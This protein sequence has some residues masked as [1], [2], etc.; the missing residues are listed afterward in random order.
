MDRAE[1]T[2]AGRDA[3][4]PGCSGRRAG[5][6]ARRL[7]ER[8]HQADE[9][10]RDAQLRQHAAELRA[11]AASIRGRAA[12]AV[13]RA[14][15]VLD[16]CQDHVRRAEAMLSPAYASA[17]REQANVARAVK[18]GEQHPAPSQPDFTDLAGR[19]SELRKRTAKAAADLVKT[20]EQVARIHDELAARER[21]SPRHKRLA[22]EAREAIRRA[23]DIERKYSDF[24]RR[25]AC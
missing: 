9:R 21:G 22:D 12:Q 25:P 11:R 17:A 15:T 24:S 7:D 10:D 20:E 8:E 16:A 6:R 19:V 18:R 2:A 4:P 5:E 3:A 23:R 1:G 14:E 13:E